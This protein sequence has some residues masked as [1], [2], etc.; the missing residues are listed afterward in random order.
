MTVYKY[1]C[2]VILSF[3]SLSHTLW[4]FLFSV[5]QIHC[6]RPPDNKQK[7]THARSCACTERTHR[8]SHTAAKW[9]FR[10]IHKWLCVEVGCFCILFGFFFTT[11]S[12]PGWTSVQFYGEHMQCAFK[13]SSTFR[14]VHTPYSL[15]STTSYYSWCKH[16][17]MLYMTSTKWHEPENLSVSRCSNSNS[18][19][20]S[21]STSSVRCEKQIV[22]KWEE[23]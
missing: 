12:I 7:P 15:F 8:K 11:S 17:E 22:E 3:S 23:Q 4:L 5:L 10:N 19:F 20:R 2:T 16:I 18:S 13:W 1:K 21:A 14:F 9:K 6:C